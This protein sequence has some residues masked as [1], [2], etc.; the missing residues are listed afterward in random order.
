[1]DTP[2]TVLQRVLRRGRPDVALLVPVPLDPPVDARHHDVVPE[3]E[4]APVVEK[5][6]F[7]VGLH[8]VGA[9]AAIVVLVSLPDDGFYFFKIKAHFDPVS[10]IAVFARFDD[11]GVVL[12]GPFLLLVL[13]DLLGSL[14]VVLQKLEVFGVLKALFDVEGQRQVG[15]HILMIVAVVVGHRVEQS[16]LVA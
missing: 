16:L 8:D 2:T 14:V 13:V 11:P 9:V 5:R 1:M 3:V 6:S 4:L 7:D 15:K 10:P 12:F